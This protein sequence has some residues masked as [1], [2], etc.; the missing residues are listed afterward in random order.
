MKNGW[1][2]MEEAPEDQSVLVTDGNSTDIAF[3]QND[4]PRWLDG[5]CVR[6]YNLIAWQPLPAPEVE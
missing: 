3:F 5:E 2:P 1:R 6:L 4:P